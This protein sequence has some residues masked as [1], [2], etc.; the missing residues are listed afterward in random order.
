MT[1]S[2]AGEP[3]RM[4]PTSYGWD[5]WLIP[6]EMSGYI[7]QSVAHISFDSNDAQHLRRSFHINFCVWDV[8]NGLL[9][10]LYIG[11]FFICIL[12]LIENRPSWSSGQ[13]GGLRWYLGC[14]S[15]LCICRF[16]GFSLVLY[17]GA[18]ENVL[19]IL[20]A[21]MVVKT[22]DMSCLVYFRRSLQ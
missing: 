9:I 22:C 3:K 4:I 15:L 7:D 14:T 5:G 6:P 2:V 1:K 17:K 8:T 20:S 21:I 11:L 18:G 13:S 12:I 19:S 16:L 10:T